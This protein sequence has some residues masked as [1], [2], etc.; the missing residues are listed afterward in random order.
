LRRSIPIRSTEGLCSI[1][2]IFSEKFNG[3]LEKLKTKT[4]EARK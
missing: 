1:D 2:K 4:E 3:F